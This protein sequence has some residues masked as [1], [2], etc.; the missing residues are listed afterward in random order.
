MCGRFTLTAALKTIQS[1]FD[2]DDDIMA[3]VTEGYRPSMNVT[4]TQSVL[5]IFPEDGKPIPALM[6]WGLVPS[7][8]KPEKTDF[9]LINARAETLTV[10]PMFRPLIAKN[11]CL[12]VADGFYEFRAEGKKKIPVR[13]SMD[14]ESLFAFAG[15]Y[16]RWKDPQSE[17][18]ILSCAIITTEPNELVRTV[19]S[20]MPAILRKEDES[21]WLDSAANT[22]DM[23]ALLVPFDHRRMRAE[24]TDPQLTAPIKK[25]KT[26]DLQLF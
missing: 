9:A 14:D 12:I 26:D 8:S 24:D 7:W 16:D 21:R 3:S 10:K 11:R 23:T 1:R 13:F 25:K 4:P 18:I 15:L 5:T 22:V 6:R 19:H 20:R 17:K 2:F